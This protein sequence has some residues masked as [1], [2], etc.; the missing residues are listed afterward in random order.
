[1]KSH[2]IQKGQ[3]ADGLI[4]LG[5]LGPFLLVSMAR[6]RE[7]KQ[8]LSAKQLSQPHG[9]LSLG[10]MCTPTLEILGLEATLCLG[11]AFAGQK[12]NIDALEANMAVCRR[13][14]FPATSHCLLNQR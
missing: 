11:S 5:R 4:Y 3:L 10:P 14:P 2:K 12:T 7:K 6:A 9:W 1:M 8:T 13:V